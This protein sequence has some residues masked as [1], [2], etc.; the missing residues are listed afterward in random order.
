MGRAVEWVWWRI[1][2]N[3]TPV[4]EKVLKVQG[5][6]GC[7]SHV[8][9]QSV[10]P[11]R[12]G[13]PEWDQAHLGEERE[14]HGAEPGGC[15]SARKWAAAGSAPGNRAA[16][17]PS[18]CLAKVQTARGGE[19]GEEPPAPQPPSGHEDGSA[20]RQDDRAH[21]PRGR[22]GHLEVGEML[23]WSPCAGLVGCPQ[24]SGSF[25]LP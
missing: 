17:A 12:W 10:P 25:P 13:G 14:A 1:L 4:E 3:P 2:G 9:G 16:V 6:S 20:L 22:G 15:C 7:G 23:G 19:S 8:Q 18:C 5:V 24:Q 21:T 11:L